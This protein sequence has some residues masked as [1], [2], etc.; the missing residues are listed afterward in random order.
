MGDPVGDAAGAGFLLRPLVALLGQPQ[1]HAALAAHCADELD[2]PMACASGESASD[3]AH[4][5]HRRCV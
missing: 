3:L 4:T 5:L 1:L 2:H